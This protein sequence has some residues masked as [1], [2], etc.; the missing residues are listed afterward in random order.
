MSHLT[1][2]H[3]PIC[4]VCTF[5]RNFETVGAMGRGGL[6]TRY[7]QRSDIKFEVH[8]EIVSHY[9]KQPFEK[10]L[11]FFP[12]SRTGLSQELI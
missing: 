6:A 10:P 4:A 3:Q 1:I 12:L 8:V 2:P 7:F 9:V 11:K 5:L